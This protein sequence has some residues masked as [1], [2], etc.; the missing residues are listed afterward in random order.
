ME[1][2]VRT[3]TVYAFSVENFNRGKD[4]VDALMELADKKLREL[5][6]HEEFIHENQVKIKIAGELD[7]LPRHVFDSAKYVM[8]KTCNYDR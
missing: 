2:G 4:E 6:E 5:V 7:L 8:D 1:M 3:V